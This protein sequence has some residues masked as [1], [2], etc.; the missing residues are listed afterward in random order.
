MSPGLVLE[1]EG[2]EGR[3]CLTGVRDEKIS[4]EV[5]GYQSV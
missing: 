1:T 3:E 4:L 5:E 2:L